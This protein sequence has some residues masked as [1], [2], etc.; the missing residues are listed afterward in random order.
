MNGRGD[1]STGWGRENCRVEVLLCILSKH[2]IIIFFCSTQ[3]NMLLGSKIF[4]FS[5]LYI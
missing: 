1:R 4:V 5:H 3:T 2:E